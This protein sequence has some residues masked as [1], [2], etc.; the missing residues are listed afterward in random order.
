MVEFIRKKCG[1]FGY[2]VEASK[3]YI[4][5]KE[6]YQEKEKHIFQ[7]SKI[8]I[9]TGHRHLGSVIGSKIFKGSYMSTINL[10]WCQKLT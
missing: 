5:V 2:H 9:T 3:S 7:E 6:Q 4:T 1:K 8:K 10:N